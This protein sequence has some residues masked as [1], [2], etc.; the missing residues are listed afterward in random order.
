MH[1]HKCIYEPKVFKLA[2]RLSLNSFICL[3]TNLPAIENEKKIRDL[4]RFRGNGPY[5]KIPTK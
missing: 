1:A 2:G 3:Y 5:G 4:D